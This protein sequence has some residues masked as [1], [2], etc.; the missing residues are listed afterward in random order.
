[1]Q[2]ASK[3]ISES[4]NGLVNATHGNK[5]VK[6]TQKTLI[7]D[8]NHLTHS[9]HH[10]PLRAARLIKPNETVKD[11]AIDYFIRQEAYKSSI[12]NDANSQTTSPSLNFK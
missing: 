4:P 5:L 10:S 9:P 7:K 8:D 6:E 11:A 12:R 1:M 2:K 3:M